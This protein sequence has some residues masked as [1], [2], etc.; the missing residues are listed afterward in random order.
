MLVDRGRSPSSVLKESMQRLLLF[1]KGTHLGAR[2][3]FVIIPVSS[4]GK[5]VAFRA[6]NRP[7]PASPI[8]VLSPWSYIKISR[9]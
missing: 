5:L 6:P 8:G 2:A 1:W 4:L 9:V 7:R 3:Y